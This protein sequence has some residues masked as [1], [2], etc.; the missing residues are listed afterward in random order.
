MDLSGFYWTDTNAD[1]VGDVGTYDMNADG[2]V[3]AMALDQNFDGYVEGYAFDSN[4]DGVIDVTTA[5]T[6]L[7]G[8][9]DATGWDTNADGAFDYYAD[10]STGGQAVATGVASS[11]TYA[12]GPSTGNSP[13]DNL[14]GLL[15]VGTSVDDVTLLRTI[16]AI[17]R[18]SGAWSTPYTYYW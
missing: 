6:N 12:I 7:D 5:D 2:Y 3:D 15:G 9:L 10:A 17:H 13:I 8:Y 16:D 18:T 14:T 11:T 4:A 1:G